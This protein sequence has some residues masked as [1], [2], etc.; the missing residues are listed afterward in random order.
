MGMMDTS[1]AARFWSKVDRDGLLPEYRPELGHCWLWRPTGRP[2]GYGH[3]GVKRRMR[4]AHIVAWEAE[5]GPVPEG[6]ELDHLCRRR[7]CVRVS[8]LEAVTK[9]VNVQRSMRYLL[10]R[11]RCYSGLHEIRSEADLYYKGAS[12]KC[13]GCR[14]CYREL[15]HKGER[16]RRERTS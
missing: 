10:T 9:R 4:L 11:G 8:H 6:R 3:F 2:D 7:N 1:T 16:Q 12:R 15:K 14:E 13:M 5:N